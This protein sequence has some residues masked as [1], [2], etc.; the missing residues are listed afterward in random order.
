[1]FKMYII[2]II[3][4]VIFSWILR[5][6]HCFLCV[7]H[8]YMKTSV[9]VI[10]IVWSIRKTVRIAEAGELDACGLANVAHG[11]ACTSREVLLRALFLVLAKSVEQR[12]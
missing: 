7:W 5:G 6:L 11:A 2:E 4:K 1:M 12:T 9:H 3:Y 8:T 10:F